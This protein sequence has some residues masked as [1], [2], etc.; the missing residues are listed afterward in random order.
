MMMGY[1]ILDMQTGDVLAALDGEDGA[2]AIVRG[3]IRERGEDYGLNLV[4]IREAW[5]GSPATVV[6]APGEL[7]ERARVPA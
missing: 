5:D 6:A 2:T 1:E 3:A 4:L 7:L